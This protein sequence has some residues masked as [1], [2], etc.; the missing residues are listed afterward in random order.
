MHTYN[1]SNLEVR[2]RRIVDRYQPR[3]ELGIPYLK[4]NQVWWSMFVVPVDQEVEVGGL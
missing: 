4:E 2:D 1:P 3:Q